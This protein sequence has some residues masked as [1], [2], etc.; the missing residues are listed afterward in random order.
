MRDK[1]Y[2]NALSWWETYMD[3]SNWNKFSAEA[4]YNYAL[5]LD[6]TD[7]T[8]EALV[9]YINTYN[10]FPGHVE[11]ST[12]SYLRSALIM[13]EKGEDLKALLILKDML[14]RLKNIEHPNKEKGLEL[15]MKW[16]ADYVPP[17]KTGK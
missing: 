2:S 9:V 3:N 17:K 14:T 7:K 10:A 6:Q 11:F 8:G 13:K 12:P 5:C 16:K 15:F 4:N 1:E